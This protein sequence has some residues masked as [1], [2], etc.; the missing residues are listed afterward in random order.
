MQLSE[1]LDNLEI[2]SE[3]KVVY[4]DEDKNERVEVTDVQEE[5]DSYIRY[6]Y[7]ENDILFI[8][9]EW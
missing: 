7:C 3:Y 5:S 1:F 6:V 8:E 2:Q 4:F 9:I